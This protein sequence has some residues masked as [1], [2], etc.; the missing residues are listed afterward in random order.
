MKKSNNGVVKILFAL[1]VLSV[2]SALIAYPVMLLYNA[3]IPA[4]FKLPAITYKNVAAFLIMVAV[5]R[6][7]ITTKITFKD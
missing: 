7:F 2:I 3:S 5:V 6:T 1:L 4:M